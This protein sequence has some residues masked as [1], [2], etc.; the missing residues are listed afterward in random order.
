MLAVFPNTDAHAHKH[1]ISWAKAGQALALIPSQT[2][3]DRAQGT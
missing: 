1:K 2:H 3:R